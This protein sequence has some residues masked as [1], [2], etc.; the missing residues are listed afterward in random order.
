MS[1]R[2]NK[3]EAIRNTVGVNITAELLLVSMVVD[4]SADPLIVAGRPALAASDSAEDTDI[5][6][7]DQVVAEFL[8]ADSDRDTDQDS[9]R[10]KSAA[11]DT[12]TALSTSFPVRRNFK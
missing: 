11:V 2:Q 5:V 3:N 9:E 10:Q 7:V 4:D 12:A 6:V 8:A 1:G